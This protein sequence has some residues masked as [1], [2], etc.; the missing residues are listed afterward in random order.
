MKIENIFIQLLMH[1]ISGVIT[2]QQ[3]LQKYPIQTNMQNTKHAMPSTRMPKIWPNLKKITRTAVITTE[4]NSRIT[5]TTN[6]SCKLQFRY[7][8]LYSE[9]L[10]VL[11]KTVFD[12]FFLNYIFKKMIAL[13][14]LIYGGML[15]DFNFQRLFRF[16]S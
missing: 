9:Q 6:M 14:Y 11:K 15:I 10:L 4:T 2:S 13:K 16:P 5:R 8:Y 3:H 12:S 1:R 7:V